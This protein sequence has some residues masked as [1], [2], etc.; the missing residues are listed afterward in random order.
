MS[1]TAWDQLILS[2]V[3]MAEGN[4]KTQEARLSGLIVRIDTW[5]ECLPQAFRIMPQTVSAPDGATIALNMFFHFVIILLYRPFYV[6]QSST[7]DEAQVAM[8]IKRSEH[9]A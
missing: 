2:D 8:A 6:S 5:W 4:A 9:S 1:F 3:V 7:N